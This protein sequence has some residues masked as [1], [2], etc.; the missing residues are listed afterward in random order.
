MTKNFSADDIIFYGGGGALIDQ[1]KNQHVRE[2]LQKHHRNIKRFVLLPHTVTGNNDLLKDLGS[3]VDIICREKISLEHVRKNTIYS[4][5][6]LMPDLAFCLDI[7]E[8]FS[9]FK[10]V[11]TSINIKNVFKEKIYSFQDIIRAYKIKLFENSTLCAFRLDKEKTSIKIPKQN[12]DV[13]SIMKRPIKNII[14]AKK[15]TI[16][17]LSFLQKFEKIKTNRLH[18]A[19]A[20]ALLGK[21]VEFYPNNYFKNYAV[22]EYSFRR[23]F[24]N[25]YWIND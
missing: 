22:F 12:L 18:V 23:N 21:I 16:R 11:K 25:V 24:A 10:D 8:L 15:I 20:G 13:S 4:N 14:I 17:F 5:V 9:N 19:I 6:M 1:S 3:N 2:F 7:K